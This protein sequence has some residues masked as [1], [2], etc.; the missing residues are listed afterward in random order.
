MTNLISFWHKHKLEVHILAKVTVIRPEQP[1][2]RALAELYDILNEVYQTSGHK[3]Y[4]K[5]DLFYTDEQIEAM[6]KDPTINWI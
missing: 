2:K 1:D 3:K 4:K 5:E 6:K